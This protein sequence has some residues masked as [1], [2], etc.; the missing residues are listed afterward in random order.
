MQLNHESGQH[1]IVDD[2]RIYY[3]EIGN[4]EGPVLLLL[5]GGM[6]TMEVFNRLLAQCPDDFGYRVIAIDSRGHGKST[7]GKKT[8]S[9]QLLQE[10]VEQVLAHLGISELSIVGYS[11]G[12]KVA[13]R[14][15]SFADLK[16]K[17]VVAVSTP[18]HDKYLEPLFPMFDAVTVG[19][20]KE[21]S[22]EDYE[23]YQRVNPEPNIEVVFDKAQQMALDL[24]SQGRPNEGVKNISSEVLVIKGEQDPFV[25]EESVEAFCELVQQAKVVVIPKAGHDVVVTR[26]DMVAKAML[27]F[28]KG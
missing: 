28:L 17:K 7:L 4:R 8:L 27:T 3:E 2:A 19:Q 6:N 20:W 22:T 26:P 10:E 25:S 21:S 18:W 16:I 14:L 5:H 23:V 1:V 12:G 9:Y 24:S 15:A 13:C 11:N